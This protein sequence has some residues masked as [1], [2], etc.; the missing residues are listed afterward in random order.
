MADVVKFQDDSIEI[1]RGAPDTLLLNQSQVEAAKQAVQKFIA[2]NPV[3]NAETDARANKMMIRLKEVSSE[4][5]D[6]RKP[7]T[8]LFDEVR[9]S[10][11]G[12]EAEIEEEF[13][14]LQKLRN[15]RAQRIMEEKRKEEE[16]NRRKAEIEQEKIVLTKEADYQ[17]RTGFIGHLT[18]AKNHVSSILESMTLDS[19]EADIDTI[20]NFPRDYQKSI[21]DRHSINLRKS[22]LLTPAEIE[23][24]VIDTRRGKFE[25]YSEEYRTTLNQFIQEL[26]LKIPG[27]ILELREIADLEIKRIEAE[28]KAKAEAE[29]RRKAIEKAN[30]EER[31]RLEEENRI[32]NEKA[33]AER[34]RLEEERKTIEAEQLERKKE[35][36]RVFEEERKELEAKAEESAELKATQATLDSMFNAATSVKPTED[37]NAIES[38]EIKVEHAAGWLLIFQFWFDKEGKNLGNEDIEKK[39]LKQMKAF[40]EKYYKKNS[41]KID[42]K[43]I[44][45]LPVYK[46]RVS[47]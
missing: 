44:S 41:E 34:I 46:T 4:I 7:L 45:Y 19:H 16:E 23:T 25:L 32:A 42:S 27:K 1:L 20:A 31:I 22:T 36:E 5:S 6:R 17:L 26:S 15:D 35:L 11:T 37:V 39:S 33:E 2:E 24:I 43:F 21:F 40:A 12:L 28:N 18:D 10:F 8:Q 14:K 38:Y 30:E 13:K 29:E 9:K 3:L 47:Q